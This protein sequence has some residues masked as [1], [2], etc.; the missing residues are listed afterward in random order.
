M[1]TGKMMV[2]SALT[3]AG[4]RANFSHSGGIITILR[5]QPQSGF[6][7]V[8]AGFF[9]ALL[10]ATLQFFDRYPVVDEKMMRK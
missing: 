8:R 9:T 5:K 10:H 1:L 4:C 2:E 7:Q 3:H 6:E